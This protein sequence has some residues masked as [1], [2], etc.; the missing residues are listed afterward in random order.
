CPRVLSPQQ[1]NLRSARRSPQAWVSPA[2]TTSNASVD[3]SGG[4]CP[5]VLSPQQMT[6]PSALRTAQAKRLAPPAD[7]LS[8]GSAG[9][10]PPITAPQQMTWPSTRTPHVKSGPAL[11]LLNRS[12]DGPGGACPKV[13]SPQQTTRPS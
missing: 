9:G 5:N 10:A 7:T 1:I 13:L 4:A 11:A 12:A 6:L 8:T 2:L 3:G